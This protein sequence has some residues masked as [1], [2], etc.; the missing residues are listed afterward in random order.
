MTPPTTSTP[1]C[2]DVWPA[3]RGRFAWFD[4]ADN[5][6]ISVMPSLINEGIYFRV[7]FCPACGAERRSTVW[8]RSED[9]P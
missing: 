1:D 5:K 7:N 8:N 9:Q 3:I 4:L 6:D 2:C